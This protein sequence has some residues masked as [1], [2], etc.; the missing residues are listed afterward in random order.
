MHKTII[1]V[2]K[3]M[4]KY[5]AEHVVDKRGKLVSMLAIPSDFERSLPRIL[6][7][8]YPSM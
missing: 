5:A 6:F 7:H 3:Y 2:Q 1:E 8:I 4:V